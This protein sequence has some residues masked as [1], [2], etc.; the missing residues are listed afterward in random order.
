M[1]VDLHLHTSRYSLCAEA[2]PF[3]LMIALIEAGYDAV[4]ITEHDAVWSDWEIQDLGAKFPAIRAF[5]GVELTLGYAPLQHLLV[6]GT[7]DPA[8]L[9]LNDPVDIVRK[10]RDEG[11]LTVA[12]HPFRWEGAAAILEQDP[13]P[14]AIE[15]RT[16]NHDASQAR[17]ALAAAV[18]RK[19]PLVN[20][21]DVHALD[22]VNRYWIETR[23]PLAEARDIRPIILGGE[24]S[25]E[26][27]ESRK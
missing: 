18:E 27:R 26:M 6:L 10:A 7:S 2:T 24:Y 13:P 16:C 5:P 20:G 22:F 3:E 15:Y 12:A 19:L 23:R 1:K 11:H 8:Y 21:G 17:R 14:D 4:F 9:T 25:N